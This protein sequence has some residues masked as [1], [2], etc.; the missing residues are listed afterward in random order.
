[1]TRALISAAAILSLVLCGTGA[2]AAAGASAP[3]PITHA[4]AIDGTSFQP[5]M[6]TVHLGDTIVW[7]NKDP[8]PHTV[9]S[10]AGGFE[11]GAITPGK[12]WKITPTKKGDFDYIC[13]FHT[14]MKATLRVQ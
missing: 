11:S 13:S 4:V 6:L 8:F 7:T 14:T 10:K 2:G 1:M 9:T 3:K 5:A 12:S